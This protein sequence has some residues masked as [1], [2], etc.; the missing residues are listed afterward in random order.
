VRENVDLDSAMSAAQL[1]DGYFEQSLV[2][3][4]PETVVARDQETQR[5]TTRATRNRR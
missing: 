1:A 5:Y 4:I 3:E 2:A